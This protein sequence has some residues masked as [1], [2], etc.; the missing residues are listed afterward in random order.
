M[1]L[2]DLPS[3]I[4]SNDSPYR[5]L[6]ETSIFPD[7]DLDPYIYVNLYIVSFVS[8]LSFLGS[9]FIVVTYIRFRRLRSFAFKLVTFLSISDFI[10]YSGKL[11]SL[12]DFSPAN[13][14]T[15]C[16]VQGIMINF[17]ELASILW[18]AAI[19]FTL[20]STVLKGK[21]NFEEEYNDKI[22]L[23]ALG[24][25]AVLT[26]IP[27]SLG[28]IGDDGDSDHCWIIFDA[29][30]RWKGFWLRMILFYVPLWLVV[31]FNAY[32]YFKLIKFL[33]TINAK[34][35]RRRISL[36]PLILVICWFFP[37]L[38]VL[39]NAFGRDNEFMNA[40]HNLSESMQG[41]LNAIIYGMN[42]DV[43]RQWKYFFKKHYDRF[44]GPKENLAEAQVTQEPLV[45]DDDVDS[46]GDERSGY[47]Y[48][49]F[50]SQSM[51]S[52]QHRPSDFNNFD[53]FEFELQDR[54]RISK[55]KRGSSYEMDLNLLQAHKTG[56]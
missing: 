49:D 24:I 11:L 17:G 36:Y 35:N 12:F 50:H 28:Y 40:L 16:N 13:Q 3:L 22:K 18:S 33:K 21:R 51:Q 55:L 31:A 42:T 25:P 30:H 14:K 46:V 26:L 4:N 8:I 29:R 37:S 27:W 56:L 53:D 54:N 10:F 20:Y 34:V 48:R 19:A 47:D 6:Q 45:N 9:I 38:H 41:I 15:V 39:S 52:M 32:V 43:N 2:H 44:F 1:P 23:V 5:T 7:F